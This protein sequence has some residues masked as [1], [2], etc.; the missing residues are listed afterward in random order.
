MPTCYLHVGMMK[1]GTSAVQRYFHNN[2]ERAAAANIVYP[3]L[4]LANHG[5]FLNAMFRPDEGTEAPERGLGW[6][7]LRE[8]REDL[9]EAFAHYLA[10]AA[11]AGRDVL[12]SAEMMFSFD[13]PMLEALRGFVTAHFDEVV[14]LAM[15]RPPL[16]YARSIAQQNVR[17]RGRLVLDDIIRSPDV[18]S[19]R[20][21][22]RLMDVFGEDAVRVGLFAGGALADGCVLQALLAMM[23]GD[24]SVLAG[25]RAWRT[26]ESI[27]ATSV[28]LFSALNESC[29]EGR[30]SPHL[31]PEVAERF[32]GGP[33]AE[34]L[35]TPDPETY[36][37]PQY[38]RIF[39]QEVLRVPGPAFVLPWAAVRRAA[40]AAEEHVEWLRETFGIDAQPADETGV[41]ERPS[42]GRLHRFARDET[43]AICHT[44]TRL[45]ERLE[46]AETPS[47]AARIAA[48]ERE[49]ARTLSLLRQAGGHRRRTLGQVVLA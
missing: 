3:H 10:W 24:R 44:L 20:A 13:A 17:V 6:A 21:F 40:A 18:P 37:T 8:R 16:A 45:A 49:V 26:N 42:V 47:Q 2:G 48:F 28:K 35:W 38:P 11:A 7:V 25:E 19:Y 9:L 5:M 36:W 32:G 27:S 12:I 22:A 23:G 39:R 15:V 4:L 1:T 43:V 29:R 34:A 31:P 14:V 30:L 33:L 41:S 46:R